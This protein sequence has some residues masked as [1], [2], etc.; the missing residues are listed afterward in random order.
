VFFKKKNSGTI[1]FWEQLDRLAGNS[2][3]DN[4]NAR[5]VFM[6]EFEAL[7]KHLGMVFHRYIENKKI[8]IYLNNNFIDPWNPFLVKEGSS[9]LGPEFLH[10]GNVEV[11]IFILPHLSKLSPEMRESGGGPNGWYD[12]Q[13]FY[14]YRN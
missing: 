9:L 11:K 6:Q 13:G 4:Q 7:E 12:H 5:K 10:P 8:K 2:A 14:I 3:P 1:V